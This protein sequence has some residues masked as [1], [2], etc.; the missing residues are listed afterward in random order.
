[1]TFGVNTSPFSGQEGKWSTSR[2]LWE[3]LQ[4][5]LRTNIALRVEPTDAKD[6]FLVSGRGELHLGILMNH[7]ARRL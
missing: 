5:E 3:R 1:M 2:K 7:A 4:D 6:V